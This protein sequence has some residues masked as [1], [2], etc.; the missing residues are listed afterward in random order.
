VQGMTVTEVKG[1]GQQKAH[2]EIHHGTEHALSFVL[3]AEGQD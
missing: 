2:A 3:C 1:F